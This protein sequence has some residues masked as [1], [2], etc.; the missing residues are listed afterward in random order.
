MGAFKRP[1][2][3]TKGT[4]LIVAVT[5]VASFGTPNPFLYTTYLNT[6]GRGRGMRTHTVVPVS[7]LPPG[8]GAA[9]ELC[10]KHEMTAA[11]PVP[12]FLRC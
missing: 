9:A 5:H 7:D 2:Q 1:T 4:L 3:K 12:L 8:G 10:P 11:L 6:H